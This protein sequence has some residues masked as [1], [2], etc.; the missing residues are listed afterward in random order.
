MATPR[1]YVSW[2]AT[3]KLDWMWARNVETAYEGALPT[4]GPGIEAGKLLLAPYARTTLTHVGDELPDGRRKL[5]H[6][7]GTVALVEVR[8]LA[9]GPYTGLFA[10]A[11]S[12]LLRF[13]DGANDGTAPS[14]A[15]KIP[16]DGR[17]SVGLLANPAISIDG[18]DPPHPM[19]VPLSSENPPPTEVA[20]KATEASFNLAAKSLCSHWRAIFQPLEP[21]AAVTTEGG[22]VSEPNAPHRVDIEYTDAARA[23]YP[24]VDDARD[25][26]AAIPEG[27][28]LA[29]LS[30]V[31]TPD[32]KSRRWAELVLK[33]R[34]VASSWG[35]ERLFFQ[36][37]PEATAND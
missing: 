24:A 4:E 35:D 13:S 22:A 33:T 14:L 21:L 26:F 23:A 28:V 6:P 11:S 27:T 15:L 37:Q 20:L 16:I 31:A 34:F 3:Q 17:P 8:V 36:H 5:I 25:G 18:D 10:R 29:T 30:T 12:A 7:Y 19:S 1:D 9:P 2:S 32:A